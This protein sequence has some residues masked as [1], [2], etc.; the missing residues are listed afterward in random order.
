MIT[1]TCFKESAFPLL[2]EITIKNEQTKWVVTKVP[3]DGEFAKYGVKE[4]D[5]IESVNGIRFEGM[6][7][8]KAFGAL[9][10]LTG[11]VNIVF[12]SD[13]APKSKTKRKRKEIEN[14]PKIRAEK[15]GEPPVFKSTRKEAAEA[16][17][18]KRNEKEKIS[19]PEVTQEQFEVQTSARVAASTTKKEL[20]SSTKRKNVID[21]DKIS[22][23]KPNFNSSSNVD[24]NEKV[25]APVSSKRSKNEKKSKIDGLPTNSKE[26]SLHSALEECPECDMKF[27]SLG[28]LSEHYTSAHTIIGPTEESE[29][30]QSGQDVKYAK[31]KQ[32]QRKG[33]SAPKIVEEERV[34]QRDAKSIRKNVLKKE[35]TRYSDHA[36]KEM[37]LLSKLKEMQEQNEVFKNDRLELN[38][39][40]RKLEA[41][42]DLENK[43]KGLDQMIKNMH[44]MKNMIGK[45]EERLENEQDLNKRE[46]DRSKVLSDELKRLKRDQNDLKNQLTESENRNKDYIAKECKE[47]DANNELRE[48]LK[49]IEEENNILNKKV[50]INREAES[51][52]RAEKVKLQNI[53]DDKIV[54]MDKLINEKTSSKLK[55]RDLEIQNENLK[56]ITE[57][58]KEALES[59]A[60]EIQNKKASL[61]EKDIKIRT[62]ENVS[63]ASNEKVVKYKGDLSKLMEKISRKEDVIEE[64]QKEK[65]EVDSSVLK[66]D[67]LEKK[68]KIYQETILQKSGLISKLEDE[69]QKLLKEKIENLPLMEEKKKSTMLQEKV[70]SA[71]R[72]NRELVKKH[73][74]EKAIRI[75]KENKE[76]QEDIQKNNEFESRLQDLK[77][78]YEHKVDK[79]TKEKERLE[80][81]L[82]SNTMEAEEK[83]LLNILKSDVK[84]LEASNDQH[85]EK[86]V[87]L[88]MENVNLKNKKDGGDVESLQKEI[89]ILEKYNE[90]LEGKC[91][92]LENENKES[93][94][95]QMHTLKRMEA[96]TEK[97][98]SLKSKKKMLKEDL[99]DQEDKIEKLKAKNKAL[100]S[101]VSHMTQLQV[102]LKTLKQQMGN[103]TENIETIEEVIS[104]KSKWDNLDDSSNERDTEHWK[105]V[106]HALDEVVNKKDKNNSVSDVSDNEADFFDS[107]KMIKLAKTKASA[108]DS[109]APNAGSENKFDD[110]N[111]GKLPAVGTEPNLK[112]MECMTSPKLKEKEVRIT[113]P[114]EKESL[115]KVIFENLERKD[116]YIRRSDSNGFKDNESLERNDHIGEI[117]KNYPGSRNGFRKERR[118]RGRERNRDRDIRAYGNRSY[119]GGYERDFDRSRLG[120]Y[121]NYFKKR[122]PYRDIDTRSSTKVRSTP[123]SLTRTSN[124]QRKWIEELTGFGLKSSLKSDLI[125]ITGH[126]SSSDKVST[127]ERSSSTEKP[128]TSTV[129]SKMSPP[130]P[131]DV[132]SRLKKIRLQTESNF[133]KRN[134]ILTEPR[135]D[136][137]LCLEEGELDDGPF[138]SRKIKTSESSP[139]SLPKFQ[140]NRTFN[141][142]I[143]SL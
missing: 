69:N 97:Y 78:D 33:K 71:E 103:N 132:S 44:E 70:L 77:K 81:I 4:G 90:D 50:Q 109:Y 10:V 79:L 128:S 87:A 107:S 48:R 14:G 110:S 66:K 42:I 17:N 3:E 39:L 102:E 84:T 11:S 143:R 24:A 89:K 45:L 61:M 67:Q 126:H 32:V 55:I 137:K 111:C 36:V 94:D 91:E 53:I 7:N 56:G 65:K 85:L 120:G 113:I 15:V 26:L 134:I 30:E 133:E 54:E 136:S 57:Q 99:K 28:L 46:K 35:E 108:N 58:Q 122:Y 105:L 12:Q 92:K 68:L 117:E 101:D 52:S 19:L 118:N 22:E 29:E 18:T 8:N 130:A 96:L 51:N 34:E 104:R 115:K 131:G 119:K 63:N 21:V 9:S 95:D 73:E 23:D 139:N 142:E 138:V 141:K 2:P 1:V 116:P 80:D 129:D 31:T 76:R 62:L 16:S 59:C 83:N 5:A 20:K 86:I 43:L 121:S 40:K 49:E 106:N 47:V 37:G 135:E 25:A 72:Q 123:E 93:L 6:D 112:E 98:E 127:F 74:E 41:N 125:P 140:T 13:F 100:R 114:K 88:Q 82:Q 64:L 75:N 27:S 60:E 124:D 38:E